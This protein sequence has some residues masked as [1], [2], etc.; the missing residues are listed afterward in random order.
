MSAYGS[1][2]TEFYD[3]DKPSAPSAAID[4]YTQKARSARGRILEPMCGS[5]R[6]LVPLIRAGLV[7]DGTDSSRHMIAACQRRL[8]IAGVCADI[9]DQPLEALSLPHR[10][11]LAF[12]PSGSI[13]L[14]TSD[15]TLLVALARIRE[16]LLP[17]ASLLLEFTEPEDEASTPDLLDLEPRAVPVP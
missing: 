15:D 6:L 14:L 2:C 17:D 12:I 8:A 3:L 11:G 10:Y 4:F 16:H 5:G 7:V 13:G 9:V 1:L